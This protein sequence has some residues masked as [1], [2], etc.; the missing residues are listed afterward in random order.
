MKR[1][2]FH[3]CDERAVVTVAVRVFDVLQLVERFD[4]MIHYCLLHA[5]PGDD[6]REI[7]LAGV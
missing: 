4:R 1:C 7:D 6:V 5:R 3:G 2:N